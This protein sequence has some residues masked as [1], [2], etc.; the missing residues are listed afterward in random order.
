MLWAE[1]GSGGKI[2]FCTYL[3][4]LVSIQMEMPVGRWIAESGILREVRDGD[5]NMGA[6]DRRRM[7]FSL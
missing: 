2:Q 3:R 6:V 4:C 5:I 1:Q 7:R